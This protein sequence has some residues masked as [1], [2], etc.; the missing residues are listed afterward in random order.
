MM[1][2]SS[3]L[4]PSSFVAYL[5][6]PP[7]LRQL[8]KDTVQSFDD[9]WL[10]P[11]QNGELFDSGKAC[12]DRLQGFAL[13]RGFAVVTTS[14]TAGRYRFGCIH[15][16]PETKNWRKLEDRVQKD[17]ESKQIVS[18]RQRE[19][20]SQ[21]ARGCNWEMYWSVRSVGKRGSGQVAGQL[22]I[23]RDTHDHILA[24]NPF[25]YKIHQKATS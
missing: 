24:P 17:P 2:H 14:S 22:G 6:C 9:A 25:I 8:I 21:N 7:Y 23:T 12:L 19:G 13:S 20:T 11:P 5:L 1:S 3:S 18:N 4:E 10:L 16:G 15:R